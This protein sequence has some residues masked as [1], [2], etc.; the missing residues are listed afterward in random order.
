MIGKHVVLTLMVGAGIY[1]VVWP[2]RLAERTIM[3]IVGVCLLASGFVLRTVARFQLGN[4][5]AVKAQ[6]TQLVTRGLYSKIRNPIYVFGSWVIRRR[7]S[8]GRPSYLAARLLGPDPTSDVAQPEGLHGAG[9]RLRRR[10]PKISREHMVLK[11]TL[12][13]VDGPPI[14]VRFCPK[15]EF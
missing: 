8:A 1:F 2:N 5:F 10:V 4:A 3:P 14:S 11:I 12:S 7:D 13:A 6:A 9:I 15:W